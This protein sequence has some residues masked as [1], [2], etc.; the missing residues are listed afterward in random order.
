MKPPRLLFISGSVGLGHVTRD[1]AIARALRQA[2]PGV[3]LDWLAAA[4]ASRV[5]RDSGENLLVQ[6]NDWADE[7]AVGADR[8]NRATERGCPFHFD[9]LGSFIANRRLHRGN[10]RLFKEAMARQAYDLVIGDE[11]YEI[12]MAL[13]D[14]QVELHVPF[15]MLYDFIGVDVERWRPLDCLAAYLINRRWAYGYR[16][17][18]ELPVTT[19][20]IGEVEDVPDRPFG[21]GLPNRR[22]WV[23]EHCHVLG[24]VLTFDPAAC[25]DRSAMRKELG[26]GEEPLVVCTTGGS[27]IGK[28]LLRLCVRSHG[29][30]RQ[31][32]PRLHTVIVGGPRP[33]FEREGAA[34][35]LTFHGYLPA[36]FKHFAAADLVVT[37]GGGTST[38]ELTALRRP[39]L[40]FPLEGH[41]EQQVHVAGRLARHGAGIR[42]R[43]S[44]TTP[45]SLAE[46]I[47]NH[48]GK[49]V[50]YPRIPVDGAQRLADL[51]RS[52]L[53]HRPETSGPTS[54]RASFLGPEIS[55][56]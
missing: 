53:G 35:G 11:T 18:P 51:A 7:T 54:V 25:A 34:E 1:L 38:L 44:A 6:A 16:R 9:V 3:E 56:K 4:P 2:L 12:L 14:R 42:M 36:L 26:Y 32:I 28:E 49:D 5:L 10:V 29:L 13:R 30:L 15:L 23:R 19:C 8:A 43:F 40:Y 22:R 39:F 31:R 41:F 21:P 24:Y 27:G 47:E 50:T 33:E 37:Q 20:F 45:E 48:M 55:R 17:A 52:L 46:M